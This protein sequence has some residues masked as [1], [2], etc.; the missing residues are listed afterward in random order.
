MG[1]SA[2]GVGMRPLQQA[3]PP[4]ER[5]ARLAGRQHGI[6]SRSQLLR[7][8][9]SESAVKRRIRAGRLIVVHPGVY[10]VGHGAL[11]F[12]GRCMA[13]VAAT[14][15][16]GVISHR[17]AAALHGLLP[18]PA[19]IE[20]SAPRGRRP[21]AR[22]A[23]HE[24]SSLDASSDLTRRRGIRVTA[25]PRTLLD[26]AEV[27][28]RASTEKCVDGA[29]VRD[30]LGPDAMLDVLARAHGRRGVPVL[31]S[32]L[33]LAVTKSELERMFLRFARR[34]GLPRPETNVRV[35][36]YEM[37]AL[38]RAAGVAVEL[39]S[40]S[41]HRGRAVFERDHDRDLA[42]APLGV[43]VLRVTY[44]QLKRQPALVE[45]ALRGTSLL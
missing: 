29:L 17:T 6:V 12:E 25:V 37:D 42:L 16:D 19:R 32:A 31:R 15:P 44:R 13:A 8:G 40:W 22:L 20:V 9:L 23:V 28:G 5:I 18:P 14:A 4:D 41:F 39:D 45:A 10:A 36:G 7:L 26:V 21:T 30:L 33:G 27:A 11:S 38:W 2:L 1:V 34:L 35:A 24:T 3:R 43:R